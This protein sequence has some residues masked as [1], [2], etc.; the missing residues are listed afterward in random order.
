MP[1]AI[2]QALARTLAAAATVAPQPDNTFPATVTT[3]RK[4]RQRRAGMIAAIMALVFSTP[5]VAAVVSP[6]GPADRD[7]AP[8]V[9]PAPPI[10]LA[11]VRPAE[12]VWPQ[13][14]VR[15]PATLPDG[16]QYTVLVK[17]DDGRY[18]VVPRIG[19]SAAQ[20]LAL[21]APST[22]AVTVPVPHVAGTGFAFEYVI[23]Q[24]QLLFTVSR[25][26]GQGAEVWS[27]S[28]R[29]GAATRL[30]TLDFPAS[31]RWAGLRPF[32]AGDAVYV[33][34]AVL[35]SRWTNPDRTYALVDGALKLIP[36]SDGWQPAGGGWL[37]KRPQYPLVTQTPT[38]SPGQRTN[39]PAV[40]QSAFTQAPSPTPPPAPPTWW[41]VATGER[42]IP[43]LPDDLDCYGLWCELGGDD[44]LD[45]FRFDASV[46]VRAHGP[47]PRL[48]SIPY[49][50]FAVVAT[51]AGG[52]Q[53]YLW[54]LRR[55]V[56]A[57]LK[58]ATQVRVHGNRF[59]VLTIEQ[60]S[61][62]MVLL[63]LTMIDR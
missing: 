14:I 19:T 11:T 28:R 34:A 1:E 59:S 10:D 54:D 20:P 9:S 7:A 12:Q 4:R 37:M 38:A 58:T 6:A 29:D 46:A 5:V 56:A 23:G 62:E 21:F 35:P 18:A 40:S 49:D 32:E 3:R 41:N 36:D 47:L 57:R 48:A 31:E 51:H 63:D 30:A 24:R 33:S 8:P 53:E 60:T 55:N 13:A 45:V 43:N 16:R 17:L 15:L 61:T 22:G 2:E 44:R 52:R 42:L 26:Q 50:Y 25:S 39:P 27:L